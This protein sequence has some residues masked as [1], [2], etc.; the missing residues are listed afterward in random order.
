MG[1]NFGHFSRSAHQKVVLRYPILGAIGEIVV[2]AVDAVALKPRIA[3]EKSLGDFVGCNPYF[4]HV[5]IRQAKGNEP[6]LQF[7]FVRFDLDS[8]CVEGPR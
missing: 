6:N 3:L 4:V 1:N 2:A 5:F 8:H 7:I